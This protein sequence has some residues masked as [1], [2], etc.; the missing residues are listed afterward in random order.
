[1]SDRPPGRSAEGGPG[2]TRNR[3]Q[4]ITTSPPPSREAGCSLAD[5]TDIAALLALSDERDMWAAR[6]LAAERDAYRRGYGDGFSGGA[7]HAWGERRALPPVIAGVGQTLAGVTRR[8]YH[9]CCRTCRR[10][11]HRDGCRRCQDRTRD[12]VGGRHPEDYRGRDG[13]P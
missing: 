1:M 4:G 3:P 12:T 6:L 11:G 10:T 5:A 7:E 8:R 9:V 13:A 2:T